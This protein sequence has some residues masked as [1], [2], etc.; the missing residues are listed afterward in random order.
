MTN[1]PAPPDGVSFAAIPSDFSRHWL[2]G[3]LPGAQENFLMVRSDW[4]FY[5]PGCTPPE[6][7]ERCRYCANL[8]QQFCKKSLDNKARK[9]SHLSEKEILERYLARLLETGWATDAE[10]RRVI[11]RTAE[12]ANWP[13]P[14]SAAP[15]SNRSSPP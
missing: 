15:K 11:R 2:A 13:V 5:T 6:L 3:A 8:A 1:V 7:L 12:L 10:M 9:R 14:V 4:R